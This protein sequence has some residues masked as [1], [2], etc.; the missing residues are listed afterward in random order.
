MSSRLPTRRVEPVRL[1]V[2]R[3]ARNAAVASAGQSTS[4]DSRLVTDAL[5]RRAGCAGRARQQRGSP[6]AARWRAP[7]RRASE[8][9]ASSSST[10]SE[11]ASSAAK[12]AS[13]RCSSAGT[14][15]PAS[16]EHVGRVDLNRRRRPGRPRPG[17]ALRG[18]PFAVVAGATGSRRLECERAPDGL[19]QRPGTEADPASR[20]SASASERARAALGRPPRGK[21]DERAH[22]RA[23]TRGRRPVRAGSRPRRS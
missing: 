20:A 10:C 6:C 18:R 16:S 19:E 1:L 17:C 5:I 21:R 3:A 12:A 4:C 13:T 7:A 11:L 23:P 2:D 9:S 22:E 14:G 15:R 8:A